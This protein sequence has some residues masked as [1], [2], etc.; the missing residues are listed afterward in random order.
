[1]WIVFIEVF[2]TKG[3]V[4]G[5]TARGIRDRRAIRASQRDG[6]QADVACSAESFAIRWCPEDS[7]VLAAETGRAISSDSVISGFG[8]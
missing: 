6:N 1:M 8:D 3:E 5:R 2:S 4:A 7:G